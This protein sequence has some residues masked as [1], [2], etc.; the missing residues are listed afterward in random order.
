MCDT[1]LS[2]KL[3]SGI[4]TCDDGIGKLSLFLVILDQFLYAQ[5]TFNVK[6]WLVIDDV[7]QGILVTDP[8]LRFFCLVQYLIN[9]IHQIYLLI[10]EKFLVCTL[11]C[12]LKYSSDSR[13]HEN[14]LLIIAARSLKW[15]YEIKQSPRWWW[16]KRQKQWRNRT[17]RVRKAAVF[18][19][20]I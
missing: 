19:N 6:L 18:T 7:G 17:A 14:Q 3:N 12:L 10:C 9:Q 16:R 2:D 15:K 5:W 4:I 8:R 20:N 13:Q 1:V 11:F